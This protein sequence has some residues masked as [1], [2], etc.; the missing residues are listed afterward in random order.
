[1]CNSGEPCKDFPDDDGAPCYSPCGGEYAVCESCLE[2]ASE[3]YGPSRWHVRNPRKTRCW[4]CDNHSKCYTI[5]TCTE[6]GRDVARHF[7]VYHSSSSD[8]EVVPDDSEE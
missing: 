4:I 3:P 1:M 5:M 7:V 6:H 8:S 2:T